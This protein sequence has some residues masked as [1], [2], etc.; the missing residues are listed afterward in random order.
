MKIIR[1]FRDGTM[2]VENES[3]VAVMG[4][5]EY[6]RIRLKAFNLRSH[7][8]DKLRQQFKHCSFAINEI[9][10]REHVFMDEIDLTN[11]SIDSIE[12]W[13]RDEKMSYDDIIEY[14]DMRILPSIVMEANKVEFERCKNSVDYFF[15][16]YVRNKG[17]ED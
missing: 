16:Y 6:E 7:I 10:S 4:A 3:F 17:S 11:L 8:L 9:M 14:V 13:M 1:K 12:F 2:L 15:K 5:D